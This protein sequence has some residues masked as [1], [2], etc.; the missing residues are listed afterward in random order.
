MVT[1]LASGGRARQAA[2]GDAASR[3]LWWRVHQWAGL[4]VS[5][6]LTFVFLTGT[7]AVF[8]YEIDWM[9]RPAMWAA[10]TP[11]AERVSW[12]TVAD[13]IGDYAPD[14]HIENI[15]A[16]IHPAA[17]FDA[18]MTEGERR[19]HIYVHPRT[20][21]VTGEGAWAGVQRFLRNTHRHLM[22]PVRYGVPIVCSTAFLLL[23][24]MVTAF[25]VYK[26][27]WRGFTRL[28]RGRTARAWL[29]DLHRIAGVWCIWFIVVIAVT[30][31]WY[32]IENFGGNAPPAP[33]PTL[34]PVSEEEFAAFDTVAA[35]DAGA[36]AALAEVP[37][38]RIDRVIGAVPGRP[39]FQLQ[40]HSGR[41]ALVRERAS[42]VWIDAGTGEVLFALDPRTLGVHQR[43]GEAADPL[44]FGTFGGYWTR[45]IWF[46]FGA[47]LTGLAMTGVA[48]YALRIAKSERR[49]PG[50]RFALGRAWRAMGPMRWPAL[51]LSLLGFVLAP[52][53]L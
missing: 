25:W 50:W 11:A 18:V 47:V 10:P 51:A 28:P 1:A 17:T 38:L 15:Y 42:S 16:P 53:V 23:A 6:F 4:Q 44:H 49:A 46:V 39:A 33:R 9:L 41:A 19:Y 43:I 12:G 34:E 8:S 3:S 13:A 27:W 22:L 2:R 21:E 31:L 45:T 7:L 40:G 37:T 35:L 24:S 5:L 20:G 29:G 14:A 48:I 30:G 26:K 32:L 36:A 52:F